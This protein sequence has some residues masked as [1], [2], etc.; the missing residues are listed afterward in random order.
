MGMTMTQKILAHH[1]GNKNVVPGQL[2]LAKLDMVL[3]NDITSPV[4]IKEFNKL[5][6]ESVFDKQKV[7]LVMDHFTPN[8]DIKAAEQCR[9]VRE[10]ANDKEIENFFDVGEMGIEHAL[11]PEKG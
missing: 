2:I 7:S 4:A 1:S 10:F 5:G 6:Y 3:G 9:F 8:K 11:L